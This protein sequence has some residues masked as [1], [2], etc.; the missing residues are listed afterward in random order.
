VAKP[1]KC[2]L[3]LH[4]W[5]YR[6]NPRPMSTTRSVCAVT[7]TETEGMQPLVLAQLEP[8]AQVL[9]KV[10]WTKPAEFGTKWSGSHVGSHRTDSSWTCA[11]QD[12]L[13]AA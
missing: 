12:G 5:E 3:R 7:P 2:R 10:C 13:F 8:P 4:N 11:D 1:L 9:D 6:E